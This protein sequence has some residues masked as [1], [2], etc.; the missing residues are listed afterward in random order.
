MYVTLQINAAPCGD[1]GS[2]VKYGVDIVSGDDGEGPRARPEEQ[3]AI[4]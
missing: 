3:M 1:K 4:R 2:G